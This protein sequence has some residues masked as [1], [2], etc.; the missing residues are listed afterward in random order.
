[1]REMLQAHFPADQIALKLAV[2]LS[3]GL[4]VGFEREW[5][6]KDVG[7]RTFALISLLGMAMALLANSFALAGFFAAIVLVLVINV[8]SILVD[9]SLEI[10]TSAALLVTYVLGALA[11]AGHLFTPVASAILMTM[12]LAWKTEL[13][14]FAGGVKPVEIR[15]AILLGLIGFV[16]YPILPNRFIDPWKLVNPREAWVTVI[17]VAALGFVNYILLR[18]YSTRGLYWSAILGGLV[19]STAAIAELAVSLRA[20]DMFGMI[21]LVNLLTVTAMLFRNLLLLAIFAP[22]A[23]IIA[24]VPLAAMGLVALLAVW[25]SR[26]RE[27]THG[28]DMG[29]S[30]PLGVG[31]VLK[32]GLLFLVIQIMGSLANRFLGNLGFLGVSVIGGFVSSATSTVAAANLAAHGSVSASSAALATILASM[33]SALVNLPIIVRKTTDRRVVSTLTA[34]TVAQL[35]AGLS[36]VALLRYLPIFSR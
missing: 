10:T 6:N 14:R 22:S 11:G 23:A 20:A 33:A 35:V 13:Q 26:K 9:R 12:L 29:L 27:P 16:I 18:L 25:F 3:I 34:F 32:F 17:V 36:C 8:R 24:V 28:G 5:S 7:I 15:S 4:L 21:T 19:N 30:S 2:A 31:R 1:M